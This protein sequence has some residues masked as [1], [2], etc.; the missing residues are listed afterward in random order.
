ML[1]Q[2]LRQIP[3]RQRP[4][5]GRDEAGNVT[6]DSLAGFK[7]DGNAGYWYNDI[8]ADSYD[9]VAKNLENVGY[10]IGSP[11]TENGLV[12]IQNGKDLKE[13]SFGDYVQVTWDVPED[14]K[15]YADAASGK[16]ISFRCGTAKSKQKNTLRWNLWI[17]TVQC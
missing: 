3:K 13:Q 4:K 6:D 7:K 11:D 14:V 8:G 9:D 1:K 16:T 15:Q 2:A 17:S 10:K 12:Q 5:I